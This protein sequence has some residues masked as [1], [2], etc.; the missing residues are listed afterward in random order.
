M[1]LGNIFSLLSENGVLNN[2]S[3]AQSTA[4]E[5]ENLV[6]SLLGG[7]QTIAAGGQTAA[8][9]GQ[10]ASDDV[11]GMILNVVQSPAA[12]A[13]IQPIVNNVASKLGIPSDTALQV[14]TFA[15]HYLASNHGS[16]IA[17]GADMSS[18]LQQ[19]SDAKFVQNNKISAQLAKQTGLDS[20]T[21]AK[22]MAAVFKQ[23]GVSN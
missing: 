10:A 2:N 4:G 21:A 7:N 12:S 23:L 3:Q 1:A 6:G 19:H 13:Y 16:K 18:I 15:I 20:Q 9:S 17:S 5:I 11:L 8:A 14:V 22:A